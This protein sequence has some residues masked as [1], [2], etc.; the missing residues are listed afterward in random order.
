MNLTIGIPLTIGLLIGNGFFVASEFALVAAKRHRLEADAANG[1]R[2]AASALAGIKELSLMLAG[3]QLG[4]TICSLGLG[5][6]SEPVIADTLTPPFHALGLPEVAAHA[7]AFV[8]A[9]GL[10]TFLHMVLGEM[11]PK[12][13]AIAHPER[14]ATLLAPPFR[15]FT[16]FVRP[17]LR[18]LNGISDL[19]LRMV[20]VRPGGEDA[21]PRTRDQLQHLVEESSRLGLIEADDHGL[22]SRALAAPDTG[23]AALVTP[24]SKIISVPASATSQEVI[25]ACAAAGRTRLLVRDGS[26]VVG[27]V[28]LR[29][30]YLARMH[31]RS[32]TAGE[33]AYT[34]P[35]LTP[36]TSVP[37]ATETLRREHS[38]VAVVRDEHGTVTGLI[39]LDDLLS[40]LLAPT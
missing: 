3:A 5:V 2:A 14:S 24:A 31:G 33:F 19:L 38:Q 32:P 25:E 27:V 15:G 18:L 8:I 39:T 4:I 16:R 23:I 20:G 26:G 34:V 37:A 35:A 17:L 22:L 36:A 13:W 10:V 1:S 40:T 11:A 9:L 30:A 7:V 21:R 28:H 12:S 29:D 6:V